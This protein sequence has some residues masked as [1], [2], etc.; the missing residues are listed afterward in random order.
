[1]PVPHMDLVILF[2]E[3]PLA[4]SDFY[5]KLFNLEPVEKSPTFAMFAFPNGIMLGLWSTKT[6]AP[7]VLGK[8]GGSEICFA[9]ENVDGVYDQW[10]KLD[11]PMAQVPTDMDFG[12]TF[13]AV[14]PD[15]HRIRVY[16][17]KEEEH[18]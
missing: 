10:L 9:D 15:G 12:R 13:V 1:M 6:A 17:T 11:I 2:V 14:D 7:T 16:R 8:P 5:G 18:A 4:S 3:N